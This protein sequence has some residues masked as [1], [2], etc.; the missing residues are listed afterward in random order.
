VFGHSLVNV[1]NA[2][3]GVPNVMQ[4]Q[5]GT[6]LAIDFAD[7]KEGPVYSSAHVEKANFMRLDNWSLGYNF[8]IKENDYI[9]GVRLYLSGQN[10]FTITNY[11]GVDPEVRYVDTGDNDNPLAPGIDRQNTYFSTRSFTLGVNV[12]F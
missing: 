12:N 6:S 10:L 2:K 9:Q 8:N 5:S 7:A 11:S 1:N 4:I 3:F